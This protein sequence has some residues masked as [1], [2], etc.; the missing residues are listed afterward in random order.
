MKYKLLSIRGRKELNIGDY[1]Q[2]LASSQFL[3]A[4]EGFVN[5]EELKSY[6]GE[7]CC[8]IMNGWFM[9]DPSQWPPSPHI[10]PIFVAFHLNSSVKDDMLSEEGINYLK[11]YEPIGCRDYFTMNL[12]HEKNIKAYFSGCLTL[13]LG[14][15]Y[16]TSIKEEKY[17]FV[18]PYYSTEKTFSF[19]LKSTIRCLRY[20]KEINQIAQKYPYRKMGWLKKRIKLSAFYCEYSK[21]FSDEILLN[22]DYICH[23]SSDYNRFQT[24]DDLLHESERLVRLYSKA[25]LVVTSRI[26][27]ALPCFGLETPVVFTPNGNWSEVDSCRLD[28]LSELFNSLY[29]KKDHL[30][31]NFMPR[32]IDMQN[33]PVNRNDWKP[34]CDKITDVLETSIENCL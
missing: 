15:T 1:V 3:P 27:C 11:R 25:R 33:L 18:D 10:H 23:Q 24:D 28:G 7:D 31:S 16:K 21:F 29:W 22:A 17:Y 26:Q 8:L 2:A 4:Q 19:L 14:K 34:I 12:L 13:T 20:Y 30:E 32:F 6:N 9:H 5:R